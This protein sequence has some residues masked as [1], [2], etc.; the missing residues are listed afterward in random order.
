M[1][2]ASRYQY[3]MLRVTFADPRGKSI[4]DI[5]RLPVHTWYTPLIASSLGMGSGRVHV[6]CGALTDERLYTDAVD[7]TLLYSKGR[8][9]KH[10]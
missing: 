8:S 7:G 1:Q 10:G 5:T 3:C 6:T 4:A 2:S 9:L